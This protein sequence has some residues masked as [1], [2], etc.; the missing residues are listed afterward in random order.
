MRSRTF[1]SAASC[2]IE[3]DFLHSDG[4]NRP[5]HRHGQGGHL[6]T[7]R[8]MQQKKAI[9]YVALMRAVGYI[10]V[11]RLSE[12]F[13]IVMGKLG[14]FT[15]MDRADIVRPSAACNKKKRSDT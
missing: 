10:L 14:Q 13:F 2:S 4:Q 11:A 12:T 5:I 1:L 7:Q 3:R 15:V 8:R 6:P 9:G